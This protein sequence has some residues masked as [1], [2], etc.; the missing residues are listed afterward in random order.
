MLLEILFGKPERWTIFVKSLNYIYAILIVN[1]I[2]MI[3]F[4][5]ESIKNLCLIFNSSQPHR[6]LTLNFF[7]C[8]TLI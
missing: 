3:E 6:L 7:K 2:R 4:K 8:K 5:L 1:L